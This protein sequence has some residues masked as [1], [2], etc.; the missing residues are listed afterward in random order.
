MKTIVIRLPDVEAAMLLELLK[1]IRLIETFR[2]FPSIK[3]KLNTR[4]PQKEEHQGNDLIH[5]RNAPHTTP[6][7]AGQFILYH[8]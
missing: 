8:A 1:V 5:L 3:S 4:R 2:V 7:A 6:S